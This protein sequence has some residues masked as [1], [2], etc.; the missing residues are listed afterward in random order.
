M[1]CWAEDILRDVVEKLLTS[2]RRND[3]TWADSE[4]FRRW[5]YRVVR[6]TIVDYV[7]RDLSPLE[8][9]QRF[10][11]RTD[12]EPSMERSHNW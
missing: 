8:R 10:S 9:A 12:G 4:H 5:L 2:I 6:N 3:K 11:R 1:P 7:R